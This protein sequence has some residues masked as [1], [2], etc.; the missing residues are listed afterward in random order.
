MRGVG[1]G[2]GCVMPTE[3]NPVGARRVMT[4]ILIDRDRTN[5]GPPEPS[6]RSIIGHACAKIVS[7]QDDHQLEIQVTVD[8]PSRDPEVWFEKT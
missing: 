4:G 1:L 8:D 2:A 7:A 5:L 6:R 3:A